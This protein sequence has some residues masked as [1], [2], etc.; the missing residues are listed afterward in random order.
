MDRHLWDILTPDS[1]EAQNAS[2][3]D[4]GAPIRDNSQQ[5][6][7]LSTTLSAVAGA[8]VAIRFG[9]KLTV[10]TI[11]PDIDDWLVLAAML[12]F[13]PASVITVYGTT[14][15]GLGRD[16]WT[17]SP[18]H[19]TTV[20][21]L[22]YILGTLYF[23]QTVL[24]K[25]AIIGFYIRIFP[26][27][28]TRRL[29]WGTFIF[30]SAWGLASVLVG[31][32]P[33]T[34]I[35]YFW[36]QW[37]GLHKGK[38]MDINAILWSHAS[39]SVALDL[40]MLAVPLWQL[41]S[42]QLHWKKKV[43]VAFMFGVGTFV[44]VVSMIRFKSLVNFGKSMNKTWELYNVSVWS[45]I[46]TTVGIMCACLPTIRAVLVKI[47]P[48][49]SASSTQR[50]KGNQY[51]EKRNSLPPMVSRMGAQ[52]V[53]TAS[54]DRPTYDEEHY[55]ETPGIVFHKTYGVRYSESDEARLV[56]EKSGDIF[57]QRKQ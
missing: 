23:A 26:M 46:E 17:L 9:Y 56:P 18:R 44:T 37:D 35:S 48:I 16:I 21:R 57:G 42:L 7:I 27:R 10:S 38:C 2:L 34:P 28:E 40:W 4:C 19:I 49:L 5:F 52:A 25:L 24:V 53:A 11:N 20:M 3:A 55:V 30:T 43:G 51:F 36:N 1:P 14:A 12:S 29:L 15:N 54:T 50:S 45:A 41:R 33:C 39:F 22:C 8:F 47:F 6:V 32:F 13:I 31:I